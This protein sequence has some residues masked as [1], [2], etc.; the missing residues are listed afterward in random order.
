[1]DKIIYQEMTLAIEEHMKEQAG[2][3]EPEPFDYDSWAE[4]HAEEKQ[5][6]INRVKLIARFGI[7]GGERDEDNFRNGS[8]N[9]LYSNLDMYKGSFKL[10]KKQGLGL[11]IYKSNGSSVVDKKIDEVRRTDEHVSSLINSA[12]S[13]TDGQKKGEIYRT[14][15]QYILERQLWR[16][17]LT[18][19]QIK[20][21]EVIPPPV[22]ENVILV[23]K[24]GPFA[25]Y[26]GEFDENKKH[27]QGTMKY[28]DGSVYIGQWENDTR[29]GQGILKFA[30]GDIYEG[31]FADGKRHGQGKYTYHEQGCSFD[32]M[33]DGGAIV[34]GQ[35]QMPDGV[36]FNGHKEDPLDRFPE[37]AKGTMW[38]PDSLQQDKE[39]F[40]RG[41]FVNGTWR[42]EELKFE[43]EDSG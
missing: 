27:G 35:W 10:D 26:D 32:G 38:F 40:V 19:K 39:C 6:D 13:E 37:D 9:S 1:M 21:G 25:C 30:N 17:P 29:N 14:A 43:L 4:N 42:P 33:W 3:E 20:K 18:R 15:A 31:Y 11:Y 2:N 7:Y 8:G 36:F 22:L 41:T 28:P 16:V 23:L 5:Y 24:Y 34:H 12:E